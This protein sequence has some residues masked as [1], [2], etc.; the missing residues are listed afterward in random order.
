MPAAPASSIA[1]L[2]RI[3]DA[4][5][6]GHMPALADV[7]WLGDGLAR[8]EAGASTGARLDDA[9]GLT[10]RRRGARN[11]WALEAVA[12]RD[13]AL[14]D[15]AATCF[16]GAKPAAIAREIAT[17]AGRYAASRWRLDQSLPIADAQRMEAPRRFLFLA[18]KSAPMPKRRQLEAILGAAKKCS[19]VDLPTAFRR[20]DAEGMS[21]GTP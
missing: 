10:A 20:A 13:A 12:R 19:Q 7:R 1:T 16:A 11:W 5:A 17:L 6:A 14:R 8:Y 9:L 18:M 4:L 3:R 15:L 21:Q 2:R